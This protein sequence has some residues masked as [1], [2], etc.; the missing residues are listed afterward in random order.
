M[1]I[2]LSQRWATLSLG[3]LLVTGVAAPPAALALPFDPLPS[4]FQRWLNAQRD[5]PHG[6]QL[7]FDQLAQ[8]SDQTAAHSPY[9]MAVFTCL[10]GRVSIRKASQPPR[11]CQLQRVSYFPANQRVRYWTSTCR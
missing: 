8:C 5:W 10:M 2:P 11:Q 4:A 7:R 3:M 6:E 1:T 9:R